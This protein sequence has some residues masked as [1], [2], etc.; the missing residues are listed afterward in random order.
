MFYQDLEQVPNGFYMVVKVKVIGYLMG[1]SHIDA[2]MIAH[3]AHVPMRTFLPYRD[4]QRTT[5]HFASL[6]VVGMVM[7]V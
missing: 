2:C 7:A 4:E 3:V 6:A 1:I 5:A